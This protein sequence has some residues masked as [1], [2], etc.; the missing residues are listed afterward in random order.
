MVQTELNF[1]LIL[2]YTKIMT[3]P[4]NNIAKVTDNV[5]IMVAVTCKKCSTFHLLWGLETR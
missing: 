4:D 3:Y 5:F 2:M 1:L